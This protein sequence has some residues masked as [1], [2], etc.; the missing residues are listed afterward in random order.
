MPSSVYRIDLITEAVEELINIKP[1]TKSPM[2]TVHLRRAPAPS[3]MASDN[4]SY[5]VGVFP[6]RRRRELI[7]I[8]VSG[9]RSQLLISIDPQTHSV[10]WLRF[11]EIQHSQFVIAA[12]RAITKLEA[13]IHIAPTNIDGAH[14][15][16]EKLLSIPSIFEAVEELVGSRA[17]Q[18][19][20]A[21]APRPSPFHKLR[22]SGMPSSKRRNQRYLRRKY[23]GQPFGTSPLPIAYKYRIQKSRRTPRLRPRR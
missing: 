18:T 6:D 5:Y 11:K 20:E 15:L 13:E 8:A 7:D 4:G 23:Q 3:N 14:E 21:K 10:K 1:V 9:V 2:L 16:V 19:Q 17:P 12:T 22:I